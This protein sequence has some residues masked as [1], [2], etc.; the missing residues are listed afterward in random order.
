MLSDLSMLCEGNPPSK[1]LITIFLKIMLLNVMIT[2]ECI[3]KQL[4]AEKGLMVHF[5]SLAQG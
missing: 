3:S 5:R 2:R 1:W 4:G